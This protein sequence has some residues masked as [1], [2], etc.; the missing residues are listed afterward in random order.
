MS[1][2]TS[3]ARG[4]DAHTSAPSIVWFRDDL[5]VADHP[6]L[7]A[8]AER[9]API[10]CVYVL[11]DAS[12]GI[13]PLGGAARW[14]LHHSLEALA[15]SLGEL[16]LELTLRRGAASDVLH[17]LV[18]ET[19]AGAVLWNRRY[20]EAE[21]ELDGS[22]KSSLRE[23]GVEANSHQAS[24]LFEPWTVLTGQGAPYR[25]FTPFYRSC[26]AEPEPR[27]PLPVVEGLEAHTGVT[28]DTL[29]DWTLLPT[30]PDWAGGLREAWTP[31]E[32]SAL[33]RLRHFLR[34]ELSSYV[35]EQD[36]PAQDATS[37]LS[38][39]LRWGEVSPF[40]VWHE[41][42]DYVK[43]LDRR[44]A[45]GAQAADGAGAFL[46][47]LVWREFSYHLLFHWPSITHANMRPAF[48]EFPWHEATP[49]IMQA[50]Q[51]GRTGIP[52]VDAGMRE[53]WKTGIMHNR[54]R[55]V[56]ASFLVK[57]LRIDW[58]EGERWFWDTLVDADSAANSV[59]WQWVA[60]SG[61]DAAPYFRVFNPELQAS[62][63][64]PH[65]EY[66]R[67]FVDDIDAE[68]YPPP[69]VDLKESRRQ[70]LDAYATITKDKA[71]GT[72]G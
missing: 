34:T 10:V 17:S 3:T 56:V 33:E 21:R 36:L 54:V 18:D 11:D 70:A 61:V 41:T 38:P 47:Q 45:E 50:W 43:S 51:Q 29:D 27:H 13:R 57:N 48:D 37:G 59:N 67:R 64:D 8:A 55:M 1:S 68:T 53:L 35:A 42:R 28:S 60:G 49:E 32:K 72:P 71:L 44:T 62:K 26:L 39:Y 20:G 6:A 63:F 46:R 22:I 66:I 25:V 16:G 58:R 40:Q 14:W 23:A 7:H 5:R 52:L 4:S 15:A 65:R 69:L 9:G 12:P 30:T 31:G 24:L 19:G 2:R